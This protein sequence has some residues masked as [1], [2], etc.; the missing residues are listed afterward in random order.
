MA[1]FSDLW[2]KFKAKVLPKIEEELKEIGDEATKVA[3]QQLDKLSSAAQ[4]KMKGLE[5][6]K[7][8]PST[9]TAPPLP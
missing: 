3:E 9:P 6:K 1:F 2:K 8:L 4:E 7:D 5:V